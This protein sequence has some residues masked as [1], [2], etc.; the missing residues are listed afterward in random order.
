MIVVTTP[1]GQVGRPLVDTLL[2][3]GEAVRVIAR[4]PEKL[5]A[6]VRERA[7]VVQGSHDDPVVVD[8][9]LAGADALFW[10]VPPNGGADDVTGYYLGF[11]RPAAQAVADH[12][13]ACVVGVTSLGRGWPEDA[14]NLSAA[15]AMDR[16]LERT[17]VHYRAL[18]MPY[19]MENLLAQAPLIRSRGIFSMPNAADRPL[20]TVATPDIAAAAGDLLL[21]RSWTGQQEAALVGPDELTPEQMAQVMAEVLERPVRFHQAA[22]EEFSAMLVGRGVNPAWAQGLVAMARAQDAGIYDAAAG[23]TRRVGPTSFRQWC[24]RE[25]RPVVEA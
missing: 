24:T 1:T 15:F 18:A 11:T 17:G 12:G 25:L 6:A 5:S 9:A 23:A 13:V 4:R 20:A 3:R 19:F 7:E 21:D 8:R 22:A 2:A 10:L 14:G 16:M